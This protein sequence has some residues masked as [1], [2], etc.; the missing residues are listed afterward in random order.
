[1]NRSEQINELAKALSAA[2]I[3]MN[4]AYKD[5]KNPFFKSSYADLKQV[6]QCFQTYYAPKGLSVSQLVGAGE[7]ETILMHTSGQYIA[8]STVL[9]VA[10]AND[11][12]ALGSS[13]SYMRRYC[14]SSLV[15][16]YQNDDDGEAA[17]ARP[18]QAPSKPLD[19]AIQAVTEIQAGGSDANDSEYIIP[20]G[21]KHNGKTL[22]EVGPSAL[23]SYVDYIK[24]EAA[25]NQKDIQGQ[26]ADFIK[27]AEAYIAEYEKTAMGSP[28]TEKDVP[29]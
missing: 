18:S 5:S 19:R 27:R 25:S 9:P 15:G 23:A 13:I 6:M 28:L 22:A 2:Q 26:V 11:P 16:I 10:K 17:A 20:F 14:L 3:E 1:M 4:G 8:S 7:I 29:F 24:R 21:K 12:Q